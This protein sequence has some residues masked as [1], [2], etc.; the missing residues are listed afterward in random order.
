MNA[1]FKPIIGVMGSHCATESDD[2]TRTIVYYLGM[3]R[4]SDPY[5]ITLKFNNV[6]C[7]LEKQIIKDFKI[8]GI[9]FDAK[10]D[11]YI[12]KGDLR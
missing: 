8:Y 4:K 10:H 12:Y 6:E 9:P 11:K 5:K 1:V 7:S 2:L 3:E